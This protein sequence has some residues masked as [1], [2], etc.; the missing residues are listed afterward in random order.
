MAW[1]RTIRGLVPW[2]IGLFLVAQLAGVVSYEYIHPTLALA[3]AAA[4]EHGHGSVGH[5]HH[6]DGTEQDSAI[7]D[8]CCAL[9]SFA[10]I[11]PL[12]VVAT[13]TDSTGERLSPGPADRASGIGP[14][15][16]DRPPRS[17]ASL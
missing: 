3:N 16:L 14:G 12:L 2:L 7:A 1:C 17:L 5:T 11:V 13:S 4:H 6:H 10:G 9:H 15:R 8:Q